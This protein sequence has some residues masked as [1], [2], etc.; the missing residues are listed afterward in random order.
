MSK[1][2]VLALLTATAQILFA[3][4][5]ASISGTVLD[6]SGSSI[7]GASVTVHSTAT[8]LSRNMKTDAQGRYLISDLPIGEYDVQGAQTGFQTVIQKGVQL[9]VGA[10]PVVDLRLPVGTAEQ[11]VNI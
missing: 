1:A 5:T 11:T 6:P 8:G 4:G 10:Q 3:Q 2:L 9:T 7:T